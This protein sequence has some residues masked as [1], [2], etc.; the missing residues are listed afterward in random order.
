MEKSQEY[1][2]NFVC[3]LP[4]RIKPNDKQPSVFQKTFGEKSLEMAKTLLKETLERET[5]HEIKNEIER[6]MELLDPKPLKQRICPDCKKP[7]TPTSKRWI[8]HRYC[9]KCGQKRYRKIE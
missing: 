8:R 2:L 5:D 7:F 6:R 3:L 1:P 9:P 4:S